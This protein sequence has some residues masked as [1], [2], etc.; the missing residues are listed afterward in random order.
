MWLQTDDVAAIG[1]ETDLVDA[2]WRDHELPATAVRAGDDSLSWL[3]YLLGRYRS[4]DMSLPQDSGLPWEPTRE[5]PGGDPGQAGATL[6]LPEGKDTMPVI[7][8]IDLPWPGAV[9]D[10]GPIELAERHW[11]IVGTIPYDGHVVLA[12]IRSPVTPTGTRS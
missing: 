5:F 1:A 4:G 9:V 12:I 2:G 6:A 7:S 10:L 8:D 11:G 3:A